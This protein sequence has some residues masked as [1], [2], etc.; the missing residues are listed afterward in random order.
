MP[1]LFVYGT[2]MDDS[3]IVRITSH[4]FKKVFATLAG[5]RREVPAGEYPQLVPD[6]GAVV[7]GFLLLDVDPESLALID[8]YEEEG[9]L[10]A[11]RQ[12]TVRA[13]GQTRNAFVYL[14]LPKN[15]A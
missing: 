14:S 7:E 12:L 2:L 10:Y 11:R 8:R 1:D 9:T 15:C 6:P 4:C 3:L 13:M 5:Y